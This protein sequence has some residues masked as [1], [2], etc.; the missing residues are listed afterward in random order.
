M[1]IPATT[2]PTTLLKKDPN[3]TIQPQTKPVPP[4]GKG[5]IGAAQSQFN[6]A[7]TPYMSENL[8]RLSAQDSP[9]VIAATTQ[10]LRAGGAMGLKNTAGTVSNVYGNV[11]RAMA[12]VAQHEAETARAFESQ[13]IQN[14]QTMDMMERDWGYKFDL[15]EDTQTFQRDLAE[16]GFDQQDSQQVGQIY[17]SLVNTML[18][19]MGGVMRQPDATWTQEMQGDFETAINASKKWL[20]GLYDI[21]LT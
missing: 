21:P 18:S 11:R 12:P 1:Y 13:R 16:M 5:I 14:Q 3:K 7:A 10:A 17:G 4:G 20:T 8:A 19:N 9:E 6:T 15:N 2:F